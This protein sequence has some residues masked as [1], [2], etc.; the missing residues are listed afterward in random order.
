M[1]HRDSDLLR[2]TKIEGIVL[3][4]RYESDVIVPDGTPTPAP[5]DPVAHYIPSARPGHRAPHVWLQRDAP[6]GSI[7]DA[8]GESFVVLT[9]PVGSAGLAAA[10]ETIE[11]ARPDLR[12]SCRIPTVPSVHLSEGTVDP[13]ASYT[14]GTTTAGTP[15][16][17]DTQVSAELTEGVELREAKH[18]EGVTI[19]RL[20]FKSANNEGPRKPFAYPRRLR[21]AA[22]LASPT[23]S[24]EAR[25]TQWWSV[26]SLHIYESARVQR[27]RQPVD[28]GDDRAVEDVPDELDE[29]GEPRLVVLGV[30]IL[31]SR[32]ASKDDRLHDH[33]REPAVKDADEGPGER[34]EG[35]PERSEAHEIKDRED[36]SQ[37]V[38]NEHARKECPFG[39]LLPRHKRTEGAHHVDALH[40]EKPRQRDQGGEDRRA[41]QP[42][43][44]RPDP[45]VRHLGPPSSVCGDP[46][47]RCARLCHA[48]LLFQGEKPPER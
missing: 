19:E 48:A 2:R 10:V 18:S 26:C 4:Y 34:I 41:Q 11:P 31:P 30:R 39:G 42:R 17:D 5:N 38:V 16:G 27:D 1:F 15:S 6:G 25:E 12:V 9:D 22:P 21:W 45:E 46:A 14:Q 8:F 33:H 13:G 29:R 47:R 44:D 40:A 7:I 28:S 43:K 24:A 37:H 35:E 3:G 36:E 23:V 20:S 32:M